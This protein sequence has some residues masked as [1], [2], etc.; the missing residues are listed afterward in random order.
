MHTS[1][2]KMF[3]LQFHISAYEDSV[4][5]HLTKILNSEQQTVVISSA[6]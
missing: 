6:K 4:A 3:S 1:K 5:A 2:K